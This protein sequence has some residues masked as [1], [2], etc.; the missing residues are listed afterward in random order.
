MDREA[1]FSSIYEML[2]KNY[3]N[4]KIIME[5]ITTKALADLLPK[6]ENLYATVTL[7]HLM[8]TLDDVA[9]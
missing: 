5:H 1:E 8:I 3:P 2:A 6:Y 7:H 9:G 4:L